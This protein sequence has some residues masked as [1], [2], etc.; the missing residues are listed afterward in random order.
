MQRQEKQNEVKEEEEGLTLVTEE[1]DNRIFSPTCRGLG[2]SPE[3]T[4]GLEQ[5][6][7]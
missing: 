2:C 6:N 4:M 3:E 1:E 5:Q 7:P